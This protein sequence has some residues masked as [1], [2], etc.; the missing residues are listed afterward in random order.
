MLD[1]QVPATWAD[2]ETRSAS[3]SVS[4]PDATTTKMI[5]NVNLRPYGSCEHVEVKL[6][7]ISG[8]LRHLGGQKV[9]LGLTAPYGQN[10]TLVA[11]AS[12]VDT[13]HLLLCV[14]FVGAVLMQAQLLPWDAL[15]AAAPGV[16]IAINCC[17]WALVHVAAAVLLMRRAPSIDD[18][19]PSADAG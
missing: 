6:G 1:A 17:V 8:E 11:T 9:R 12:A 4:A 19:A 18:A 14:G 3:I 5:V 13:S 2:N 7:S 15:P 10:A 16:A